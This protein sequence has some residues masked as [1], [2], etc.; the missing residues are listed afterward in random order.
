M[1]NSIHTRPDCHSAVAT[2]VTSL[3]FTRPDPF[4]R[5]PEEAHHRGGAWVDGRR[6]PGEWPNSRGAEWVVTTAD[7]LEIRALVANSGSRSTPGLTGA[8]SERV[9]GQLGFRFNPDHRGMLA[10]VLPSGR[11][12]PDWRH[13]PIDELRHRL[14]GPVDGVLFDIEHNVFWPPS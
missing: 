2:N 8:E 10:E 13:G 1:L 6:S 3:R 7:E 14:A 11:G 12:W 9:E 5:R 4:Q